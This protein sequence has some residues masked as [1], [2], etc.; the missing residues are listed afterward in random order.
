MKIFTTG[1]MGFIGT[2]L[3]NVLT[4][5]RHK[6]TVLKRN[7]K[8][9]WLVP[10]GVL[11]IEGDSTKRG[12]WQEKLAEHDAIINLAGTS[13]FQRWNNEVKKAIYDSRILTTRNIVEA[14]AARKGKETVLLSTSGV[15]YYGYSGDGLLDENNPPGR[16]FLAK[17]AADWEAEALKAAHYGARVVLCRFG[18]VLG[19]SGGVL[20]Q[21][22]PV[23]KRYLGSPLGNGKQWFSWI[24]EK[25]LANIILFLL[26][27]KEI[28][29]PVNCTAPHP[30]R[31]REF[32]KVLSEVLGK[33]IVMPL[34]PSFMLRLFFGEFANVILKGQRVVPRKLLDNG[35]H[36]EF[37]TIKEAMQ[38]LLRSY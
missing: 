38:D 23:F 36:F 15:G 33:P 37:P 31:N 25:D 29:G 20:R 24:H 21:L 10:N 19:R 16:D 26:D 5:H 4:S 13:I 9:R 30:V 35:F 8:K 27:R 2:T 22:V 12:I 11:C 17:L 34:V 7:K 32:T 18:I 1:A 14:L 28:E 6:V 3:I